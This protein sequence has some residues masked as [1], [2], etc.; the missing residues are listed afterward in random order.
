MNP[1]LLEHGLKAGEVCEL[2][3]SLLLPESFKEKEQL[4]LQFYFT[5]FEG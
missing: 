3:I 2:S 1:V 5:D 4:L